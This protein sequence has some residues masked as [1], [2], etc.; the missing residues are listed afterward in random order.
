M[1]DNQPTATAMIYCG[2]NVAGVYCMS[3]RNEYRHKGLGT[4]AVNA[5]ISLAKSKNLHHAILYA[6]QLGQP[7]YAKLGFKET[8]ILQEYYLA[9]TLEQSND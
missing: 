4:A 2:N 5:C 7:L 6:S 8:Q 3:T 1:Y 9:N